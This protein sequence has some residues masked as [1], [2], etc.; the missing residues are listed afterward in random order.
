MTGFLGGALL[1]KGDFVKA[2]EN[3]REA[4]SHRKVFDPTNMQLGDCLRAEAQ[5]LYYLHNYPEAEAKIDECLKIYRK[6][7]NPHYINFATAIMIQGMIYAQTNRVMEAE[8]LLREAVQI[9]A[10]NAPE[11]HFVRAVADGELSEFLAIQKRFDQ[12]EPLLLH[13]YEAL[14][15][16]QSPNSRRLRIA[17]ERLVALYDR[18]GKPQIANQYR[19]NR[20]EPKF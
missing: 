14:K 8:K 2:E 15:K 4:E 20:S 16:S 12:A 3:L 1:G 13:S 6:W 7:T 17:L 5:S 10:Q 11:T 9:R 19:G 18:W